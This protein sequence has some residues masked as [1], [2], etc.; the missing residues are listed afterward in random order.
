MNALRL[1][2][3]SSPG[4]QKIRV[5]LVTHFFRD[6]KRNDRVLLVSLKVVG[7]GMCKIAVLV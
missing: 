2:Y 7:Q 1:Q 3:T 4:V 6:E 5:L